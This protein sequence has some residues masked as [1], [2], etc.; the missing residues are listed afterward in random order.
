MP[1]RPRLRDERGA[2][3]VEAALVLPLVIILIFG[4]IEFALLLKDTTAV[5]ESARVGV[6]TASAL[7]K[8]TEFT[9]RTADAI[10]RAG[11]AMN[12]DDVDF[13]L[14]YR[15]NA[16]GLPGTFTPATF[17]RDATSACVGFETTCDRFVWNDA[18]NRF[19][20]TNTP[21]WLATSVN[22]CPG[23]QLDAVGVYVQAS[24]R[25]VTGL[26]GGTRLLRDRA[27]LKFEPRGA[28]QCKPTS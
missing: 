8:E 4:V 1:R 9:Q 2:V 24:H 18:T 27:V 25:M 21:T 16:D 12:K 22:A 26:F 28:G 7:S 23:P 11:S 15:A 19:N 3:A 20:P 14:V 13:I 17:P 5:S 10:A 6:R